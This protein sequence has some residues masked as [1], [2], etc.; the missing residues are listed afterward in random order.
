VEPVPDA[1]LIRTHTRIV[2]KLNEDAVTQCDV[3][4]LRTVITCSTDSANKMDVLAV[5][6]LSLARYDFHERIIF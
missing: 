6:Y 3:R 2:L 1:L 4:A 5:V